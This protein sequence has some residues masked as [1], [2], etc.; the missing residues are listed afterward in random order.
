[1]LLTQA[2]SHQDTL[3]PIPRNAAPVPTYAIKADDRRRV[4]VLNSYHFGYSWS[5]NE[6]SGILE[7]FRSQ[8]PGVELVIEY[9]DCKQFPRMNHFPSLVGLLKAKYSTSR[10]DLVMTA[11][12]PALELALKYRE[13]LFPG[14]PIVF[15]GINGFE[16]SQMAGVK[17]VTGVAEILDAAATLELALQLQ[18]DTREV[19][20]IHDRSITG[21]SSRRETEA[22]LQHFAGSI[23]IRYLE[24]MPMQDMLRALKQLSPETIVLALSFSIDKEG[25]I[26]DHQQLAELLGKYCPVPVY[27][28]H[29]ERVGYGVVGGHVLSGRSQGKRAAELALSILG[30]SDPAG[31]PVVLQ[32]PSEWLFDVAQL[33]R[34][35]LPGTKLPPE[36]ILLNQPV[37]FFETH[38][39]IVLSAAA[40][41]ALLTLGILILL[42]N[43]FRRQ[44]AEVALAD[45]E[46][47]FRKLFETAADMT[48]VLRPDGLIIQANAQAARTLEISQSDFVGLHFRGIIVSGQAETVMA[49]I[50]ET[51]SQGQMAF[52]SILQ[53]TGGKCVPADIICSSLDFDEGKAIICSARDLT[54]RKK[55]EA[56]TKSL[57]EELAHAQKMESIGFLAGGIA[58]DFNNILTSIIGYGELAALQLSEDSPAKGYFLHIQAAGEKAARLTRQ[59]LAFSRK[60]ALHVEPLNLRL[61]VREII[62]IIKPLLREDIELII[63]EDGPIENI[64][65]DRTQIEQILMNLTVNARDAMPDGGKL[66]LETKTVQQPSAR[67]G[68]DVPVGS[69]EYAMLLVSDSGIGIPREIQSKIFE[70]FFTT[71]G[72][73]KGTGLG[74]STVYGIVKQHGGNIDFS[75]EPGKGTT[76]HVSFP[77]TTEISQPPI[78]HV[79]KPHGGNETILVV[80]DDQTVAKLIFDILQPLGY[81]ILL[82]SGPK[83][84]IEIS[85]THS[86]IIDLL[87]TDVIMPGMNGRKLAELILA[88]QSSLKVIYMSGYTDNIIAHHGILEKGVELI[89]KPITPKIL[90]ERLRTAMG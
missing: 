34:F 14:I 21:L 26:Y 70:P 27:V 56:A 19:V 30:G 18:P 57:Q 54:E 85:D 23:R 65:A 61:V 37:S 79:V 10:I 71:K 45:S 44:L 5:D 9:L 25:L 67:A 74:L 29:E 40:L 59:L 76:F 35:H 28:V 4:L 86:G 39:S 82:A 38:R 84:A 32:S 81:K 43:I 50:S 78:T 17:G 7:T 15:C 3:L 12:N 48:F 36:S 53:G 6:I 73:G 55:T 90:I 22:Q 46:Y 24:E 49:Q 41:I 80:D 11:D 47:R 8:A 42:I 68:G 69:G 72:V 89:Q 20:V 31:I 75:S 13:E 16:P 51:L 77:V 62:S 66:V 88:R 83:E 2:L 58:H 63:R 64:L 1:M 33:Q 87:L 60:Q 52:E